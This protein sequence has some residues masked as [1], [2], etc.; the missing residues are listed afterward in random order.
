[1]HWR[2]WLRAFD[3]VIRLA[4]LPIRSLPY[5]IRWGQLLIP[6]AAA[7]VG[8]AVPKALHL[9]RWQ[10]LV[11]VFGIAFLA[12]L[13]AAVRLSLAQ[14]PTFPKVEVWVGGPSFELATTD[15][16]SGT[17]LDMNQKNILLR[18]VRITSL[19]HH[20]LSMSLD[21]FVELRAESEPRHFEVRAWPVRSTEP[22]YLS[23]PINIPP[24]RSAAGDMRFFRSAVHDG[25]D[26]SVRVEIED[27]HSGLRICVPE[28]GKPF[29]P[30]ELA[31]RWRNDES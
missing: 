1:M 23:N 2:Q 6:V 11:V 9:S 4:F 3:E 22:G 29:R 14:L 27:H 20:D 19:E 17:P 16:H 25:D 31:R 12:V 18:D 28:L 26:R 5:W 13:V 8:L 10:V 24:L 7:A 21:A 30:H 15:P